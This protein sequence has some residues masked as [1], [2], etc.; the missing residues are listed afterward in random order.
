MDEEDQAAQDNE[1]EEDVEFLA[2]IVNGK[3]Q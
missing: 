1:D 3:S 2:K